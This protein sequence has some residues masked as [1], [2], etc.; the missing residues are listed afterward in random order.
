MGAWE[1]MP[2]VPFSSACGLWGVLFTSASFVY[3]LLLTSV[4]SHDQ[5]ILQFS[6]FS[7]HC[8]S[9][10]VET[11]IEL[12]THIN[13]EQ[14]TV[15][16]VCFPSILATSAV[17]T[18]ICQPLCTS[19][20]GPME[21]LHVALGSSLLATSLIL[22]LTGWMPV[23]ALNY[24]YWKTLFWISMCPM[25]RNLAHYIWFCWLWA[26][27]LQNSLAGILMPYCILHAAFFPRGIENNCTLVTF[28]LSR[29]VIFSDSSCQEE[30]LS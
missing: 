1:V 8:W 29:L 5:N 2:T 10:I 7:T 20:K 21:T 13:T 3:S 19:L 12:K 16:W 30:L 4:A 26:L 22:I 18:Y 24:E 9:L 28:V 17:A 14:H 11:I 6:M 23:S 27:F 15:F 25:T